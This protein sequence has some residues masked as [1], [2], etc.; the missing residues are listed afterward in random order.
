M[1]RDSNPDFFSEAVAKGADFLERDETDFARWSLLMVHQFGEQ[2][3]PDLEDIWMFA[4]N[5][6]QRREEAAPSLPPGGPPAPA[7]GPAVPWWRRKLP[8]SVLVLFYAV[9]VGLFLVSGWL[10]WRERK[11]QEAAAEV[12]DAAKQGQPVASAQTD[13]GS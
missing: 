3:R 8:K 4:H 10:G 9:I 5:E 12:A 7:C 6:R 1:T 2:I 11:A 13:A